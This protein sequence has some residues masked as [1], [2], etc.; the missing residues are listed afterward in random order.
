MHRIGLSKDTGFSCACTEQTNHVLN[1]EETFLIVILRGLKH[2]PSCKV[3]LDLMA[4][5]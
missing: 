4:I 3:T 1:M 2:N 5:P